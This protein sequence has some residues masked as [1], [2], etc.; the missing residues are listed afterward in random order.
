MSDP[1]RYLPALALAVA[2]SACASP[3]YQSRGVYTQTL[4][5]RAYG[6]GRR[7]GLV[8]GR[9]DARSGRNFSYARSTAYRDADSGYRRQD[10]S[11]DA[12]RQIFRQGFQAGYTEGF[13]Q[14]A[15]TFPRTAPYPGGTRSGIYTSPAGESGYRD[16]FE[17]GRNDARHRGPFD[18]QRSSRYR[19]A[20]HNYNRRYGSKDD[21]KREYR[22]AFQR[23]YQEGFTGAR[24]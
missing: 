10:G 7:E 15:R 6:N 16:G 8:R 2:T 23:G 17:A 24:R 19:S 3:F 5:Q 11:R 22:V 21:Y 12:Y 13:N 20:D 4:E 14:F 9:D 1:F 18:P